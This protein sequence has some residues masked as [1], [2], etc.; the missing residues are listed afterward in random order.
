MKTAERMAA[1]P[2]A[3]LHPDPT[4]VEVYPAA[5]GGLAPAGIRTHSVRMRGMVAHQEVILGATARR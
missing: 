3:R 5:R 4:E 2:A 1:A